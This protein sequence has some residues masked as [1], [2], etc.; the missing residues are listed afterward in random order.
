MATGPFQWQRNGAFFLANGSTPLALDNFMLWEGP[1]GASLVSTFVDIRLYVLVSGAGTGVELEWWQDVVA[2]VGVYW[3][4]NPVIPATVPTPI[5]FPTP[6]EP[7]VLNNNLYPK[8]DIFDVASPTENITWSNP[9][10]TIHVSG[11]RRSDPAQ[12]NTLWL[13]WEVA[14]NSGFINTT[15][16]SMNYYLGATFWVSALYEL[17]S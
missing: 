9:T 10:G 6:D 17:H 15:V 1:A 7:W 12:H 11:K 14:D 5:S 16:A 8:V 4:D 2:N 13:T 3:D